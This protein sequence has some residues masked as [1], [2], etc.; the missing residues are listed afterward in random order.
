MKDTAKKIQ[1]RIRKE[2]V[3]IRLPKAAGIP[4]FPRC[5]RTVVSRR[6]ATR[7]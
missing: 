1:S 2:R 3:D 7:S 6:D 4:D 5:L